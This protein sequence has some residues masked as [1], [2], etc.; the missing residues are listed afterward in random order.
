[1]AVNGAI[2]KTIFSDTTVTTSQKINPVHITELRAAITRLQGYAANVD[3]CGNCT[4][5]QTCQGATCQSAACQS[6]SCQ[7]VSCQS[8]QSYTCQ[9]MECNCDCSDDM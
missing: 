9:S 5:C 1:M 3:N 4:Y 7:S 6:V 8:C 2:T